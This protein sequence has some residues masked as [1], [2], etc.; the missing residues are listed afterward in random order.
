MIEK[1]VS[2]IKNKADM[3]EVYFSDSN[4][5][6]IEGESMKPNFVSEGTTKALALRVVVDKKIGVASTLNIN[7]YKECVNNA[8]KIAKLNNVDKDF[9]N[10]AFPDKYKRII[11]FSKSLVNFGSED[12]IKL[13]KN[14]VNEVTN[15]NKNIEFVK[16]IY[17]KNMNNRRI[18]NSNGIDVEDKTV[19]NSFVYTLRLGGEAIDLY[20]S[21]VSILTTKNVGETVERLESLFNKQKIKNARVPV[22]L[23]QNALSTFL[24]HTFT[25]NIDA[26][27]VQKGKS[28]FKNMVGKKI[29]DKNVNICDDGIK[30]GLINSRSFDDEGVPS[31]KTDIIKDGVLKGFLYDVYTANKENRKS[32]GNAVR[33]L[34][35]IPKIKTNNLV[36][37]KGNKTKEQLIDSIDKGL[38]IISTMGGHTMN[39]STGDF[40]LVVS[41]GHYIENGKIKY[42]VKDVMISGNFYDMLNKIE[43]IGKEIKH[44][45]DGYY[46]P[47]ILFSE[48]NVIC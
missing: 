6:N 14:I 9:K 4:L 29:A 19:D 30:K 18:I 40:S 12:F 27:N 20:D 41:E 16:I 2:Y 28:L 21:D 1:V 22:M 13:N 24:D 15:L 25:F 37:G 7:N 45:D 35:F 48:V 38:Y 10:F 26:E 33:G 42:P 44:Y 46:L 3:Y 34:N 17:Y 43:C 39:E 36:F 11:N 5:L 31:K 8:I 47:L 32:T 23:H